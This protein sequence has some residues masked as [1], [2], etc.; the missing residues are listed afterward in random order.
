MRFVFD[1]ESNGLHGQGFAVGWVV[2]D[3]GEVLSSGFLRCSIEG[4]INPWV[5]ENVIPNLDDENCETSLDLRDGFWGAW[6]LAKEQG[7]T[8][9]A[10]CSFPVETNFLAE[11]VDDLPNHRQWLAP[12]PLHEIATVLCLNGLDAIYR[13]DRLDGE[14]AHHPTGDARQSARL[15]QQFFP[16]HHQD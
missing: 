2:V 5:F 3:H 9:W 4:K 14:T 13:H 11:C 15:L 8:A 16:E 10:D 7:A 1:V 12:Y 6:M